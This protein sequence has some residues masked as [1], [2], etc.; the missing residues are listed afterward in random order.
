MK[1]KVL[2][3]S[4]RMMQRV[5]RP[6][7][8]EKTLSTDW[9]T[10]Q[11]LFLKGPVSEKTQH[12]VDLTV[13]DMLTWMRVNKHQMERLSLDS[14]RTSSRDQNHP[15]LTHQSKFP[16][17][18]WLAGHSSTQTINSLMGLITVSINSNCSINQSFCYLWKNCV[19]SDYVHT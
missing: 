14:V 19:L 16:I 18:F 17:N 4:E 7:W 8:P 12:L 9:N 3:V 11:K 10:L 5:T 6:K 13:P 2:A 1:I 15:S